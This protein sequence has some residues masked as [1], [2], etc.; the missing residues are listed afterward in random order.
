MTLPHHSTAH[1][2]RE[3]SDIWGK[4][5]WF[6]LLRDAF[7]VELGTCAQILCWDYLDTA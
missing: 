3:F 7:V 6:L 2:I 5:F 4:K 1:V